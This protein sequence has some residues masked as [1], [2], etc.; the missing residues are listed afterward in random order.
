MVS[1]KTV[2]GSVVQLTLFLFATCWLVK[3]Q[4]IYSSDV[5]EK[6]KRG[7]NA[8]LILIR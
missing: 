7:K 5:I 6:L 3:G 4:L 8:D 1:C 2:A